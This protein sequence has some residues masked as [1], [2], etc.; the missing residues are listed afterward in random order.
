MTAKDTS[1]SAMAAPKPSLKR[2]RAE[3]DEI[4]SIRF[5]GLDPVAAADRTGTNSTVATQNR[6]GVSS[7]KR[8]RL[9]MTKHKKGG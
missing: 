7:S 9:T 1:T 3:S 2:S 8:V 5:S 6:G 4:D